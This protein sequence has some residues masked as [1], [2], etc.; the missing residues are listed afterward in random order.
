MSVKVTYTDKDGKPATLT[1]PNARLAEMYGKTV[2]NPTYTIGVVEAAPVEVIK[3]GTPGHENYKRR[4][5]ALLT[6]TSAQEQAEAYMSEG[7]VSLLQGEETP[8]ALVADAWSSSNVGAS[9]V[10]KEVLCICGNK[11]VK[12]LTSCY[13]CRRYA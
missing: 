5:A 11:C 8:H 12:G 9:E 1:F 2:K 13:I 3:C 4:Q 6:E 10:E 7:I